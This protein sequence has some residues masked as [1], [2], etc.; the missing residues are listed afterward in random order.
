MNTEALTLAA[1]ETCMTI[2]RVG[3]LMG[4]IGQPRSSAS[5]YRSCGG[6][7]A[8]QLLCYAQ[9]G[10][11]RTVNNQYLRFGYNALLNVADLAACM[12]PLASGAGRLRTV[13]FRPKALR[14]IG[15]SCRAAALFTK[16]CKPRMNERDAAI[17]ATLARLRLGDSLLKL[18]AMMV[19]YAV[20]ETRCQCAA[21]QLVA[22]VVREMEAERATTAADALEK[23]T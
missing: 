1:T 5:P 22:R 7:F 16:N 15:S 14:K 11:L 10:K 17:E 18:S 6:R 13:G 21:A 9:E 8:G 4:D 20:R 3:E 19:T 12:E 2:Q 23:V